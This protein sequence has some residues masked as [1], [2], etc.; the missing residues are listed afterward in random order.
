MLA[1]PTCSWRA[2]RRQLRPEFFRRRSGVPRATPRRRCS[3]LPTLAHAVHQGRAPETGAGHAEV[4]LD[5]AL[6]SRL[7]GPGPRGHRCPGGGRGHDGRELLHARR[8]C[9]RAQRDAQRLGQHR[10]ARRHLRR[11]GRLQLL[12]RSRSEHRRGNVDRLGDARGRVERPGRARGVAGRDLPADVRF[13]ARAGHRRAR[14]GR[15]VEHHADRGAAGRGLGSDGRRAGQ[16]RPVQRRRSG[17]R[18]RAP[19]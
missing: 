16:L 10:R 18:A 12:R 4:D 15:R 11:A 5:Q 6:G 17:S 9:E 13:D 7:R 19:A 14:D 2:R 1:H 3:A 8:A